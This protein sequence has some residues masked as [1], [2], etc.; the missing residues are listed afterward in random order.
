MSILNQNLQNALEQIRGVHPLLHCISNIVTAN[1]C[2]NLALAIGASPIM[3]QEPQEMAQI[4]AMAQAVI[5]NTGT[6]DES[7][8]QAAIIA[9][10]TANQLHIPVILDPVGVG[11]STWRLNHIH[12][13]LTQVHPDILRVNLGEAKALLGQTGTEHG[14]DS[15]E[16][17]QYAEISAYA[18][19]L[20]NALHTTVLLS[21]EEDL[22]TDGVR[23][24][25][26]TG[27]SPLTRSVTGAGCMLSVLCG[28]FAS[29]EPPS[30]DSSHASASQPDY[31]TSACHA[32]HFWKL[33]AETAAQASS[34]P[35]SFRVG[36]FDAA[37]KLSIFNEKRI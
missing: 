36:L 24:T 20:A 32:A 26:I 18:M 2:A 29:V 16:A 19:E 14:V 23:L 30:T 12:D 33:C 6:P 25:K 13:L 11:A 21:G 22:V 34:A 3:A 1:D 4:A 15:L 10:K 28:A 17:P 7:K 9:G 27:G 37:Y 5:L 31:Y 8:F 35:G